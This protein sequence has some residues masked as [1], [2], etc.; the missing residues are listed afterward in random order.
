MSRLSHLLRKLLK[1]LFYFNTALFTSCDICRSM[2]KVLLFNFQ[3]VKTANF[4]FKSKMKTANLQFS[5]P[6]LTKCRTKTHKIHV[7]LNT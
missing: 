6:C 3:C 2:Q 5:K 7:H 4:P 1:H